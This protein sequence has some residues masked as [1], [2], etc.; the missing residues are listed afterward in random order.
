MRMW[1]IVEG[2]N[3][4]PRS[5][6][7][8]DWLWTLALNSGDIRHLLFRYPGTT[9]ATAPDHLPPQVL[10]AVESYGR[11]AL[12]KMLEWPELPAEIAAGSEWLALIHRNGSFSHVG[13]EPPHSHRAPALRTQWFFERNKISVNHRGGIQAQYAFSN[14]RWNKNLLVRG[15]VKQGPEPLML[16]DVLAELRD[17]IDRQHALDLDPKGAASLPPLSLQAAA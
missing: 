7:S 16:G 1:S 4:Q 14:G 3:P 8:T 12:E 5:G 11:S 13:M 15:F 2:P 17:K 9:R 6:D 10:A